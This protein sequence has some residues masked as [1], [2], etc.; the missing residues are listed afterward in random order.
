MI[1]IPASDG[2][3]VDT[4]LDLGEELLDLCEE[5]PE[6][7]DDFRASVEEKAHSILDA[8][9]QFDRCSKA[10]YQALQNMLSGVKKWL[11]RE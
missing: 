5:L 1:L 10:Q 6:R 3:S 8:I 4:A 9:E 7:A 11:E 2:P